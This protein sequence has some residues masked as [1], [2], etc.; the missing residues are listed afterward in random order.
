MES[1]GR[2]KG[3][4]MKGLMDRRVKEG[5]PSRARGLRKKRSIYELIPQY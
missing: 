4:R 2:K 5:D 3:Q 1:T